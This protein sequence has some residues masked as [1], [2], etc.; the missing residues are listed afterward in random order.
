MSLVNSI[1]S[2]TMPFLPRWAAKPFAKPYV[3]GESIDEVLEIVQSLNSDNF[4]ATI[5][6]LGEFTRTKDEAVAI[7]MQYEE[8]IN[9]ISAKS[10]DS[11]ISIKLTHLGLDL[12]YAFCEKQLLKL[13]AYGQKKDVAITI[14]MESSKHT[15]DIYKLFRKANQLFSKVGAVTQAYLYR[16]IDDVTQ[17]SRVN[18]NLRICKGIYKESSKIA[19]KEK[20]KINENFELLA[21]AIFD[22]EGYASLATHDLKLISNLEK[23]IQKREIPLDRFEFQVLYGVPMKSKLEE[24]KAKGYKVTVYVPFGKSWFDYSIR[25]LKENPKIVSYVIKNLFKK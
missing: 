6:I 7:R 10:I 12:D 24:L 22:G 23:L 20:N 14:D 13:S 8:L 21:K 18:C 16:S 4:S 9:L 1:I 11:S 3:A 5:D 15:D 25:R 2:K 19:I 17:F